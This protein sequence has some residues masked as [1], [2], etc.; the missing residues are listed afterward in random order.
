MI[1]DRVKTSAKFIMQNPGHVRINYAKLDTS[2]E[3]VFNNKSFDEFADSSNHPNQKD[4]L[5]IESYLFFTFATDAMNF[6]FWPFNKEYEDLTA[7]IKEHIKSGELSVKNLL[8]MSYN[9]FYEL[10]VKLFDSDPYNQLEERFRILQELASVISGDFNGSFKNVLLSANMDASMLLKIVTEKL[11]SFQDHCIYR[12]RQVFFYKRAQILVGDV[13]ETLKAIAAYKDDLSEED[14]IFAENNKIGQGLSNINTLTCFADYRVPQVLHM[15][16]LVEYTP[17][18]QA[19]IENKIVLPNGSEEE[20]EIRAA[21]IHSIELLKEKIK[22]VYNYDL[23]SIE[24][25]WIMWQYGEKH[26]K[27]SYPFHRTIGIYY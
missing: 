6:C 12:G 1:S 16:G 10:F 15:L 18:L 3:W 25:D 8:L 14:K 11:T 24:I 4:L 5:D 13:N 19:S 27:D 23:M 26:L 20:S 21:M 2:A 17:S 22:E 7:F 9:E